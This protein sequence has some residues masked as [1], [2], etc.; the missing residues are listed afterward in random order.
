MPNITSVSYISGALSSTVSG[1]VSTLDNLITSGGTASTNVLTVQG[2]SGGVSMPVT[3]TLTSGGAINPNGQATMANSAPVVMASD[4]PAIKGYYVAV[5]ASQTTQVLQ[6]STGAA[7]DYLDHVTIIP[8][9]TAP[10]VVT[11]IDNA[12][13]LYAYPGGGT[14]ALLTLTP[15]TIQ[16]QAFS[17][18]G[19]WK[20][21][22]GANVSVVAV[23]K[24]S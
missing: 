23:G 12:T 11:I 24:F 17:R 2:T 1:T 21:T 7:G 19:A 3:A 8:A 18:S 5:A 14:T 6:S 15:F 10:G 20:I 16:V 9:T 4:L 13:T 22:T